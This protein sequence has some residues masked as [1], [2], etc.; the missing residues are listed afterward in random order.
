MAKLSTPRRNKLP[1]SKFGE[2]GSRKYPMPDKSHAANAKARASQQ[3]KKGNLSKSEEA[4]I[5]SKA[6]KVLGSGHHDGESGHSGH[7]GKGKSEMEK[8]KA[9]AHR[10][11]MA[12]KATGGKEH[13]RAETKDHKAKAH[14]P[15]MHE[16]KE[17][18]GKEH[19]RKGRAEHKPEHKPEHHKP[20]HHKGKEHEGRKVH[21]R[22]AE[23]KGEHAS[24]AHHEGAHK[25]VHVHHHVHHHGQKA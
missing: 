19:A 20:E 5:D 17:H 10:E 23:H 9:E 4:K 14:H 2:P 25:V 15:K 24:K 8:T 21:E 7:D 11:R 13:H 18:E 22:K 3:V 12:K 1:A 16:R 6:N